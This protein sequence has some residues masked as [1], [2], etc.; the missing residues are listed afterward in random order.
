MLGRMT[1]ETE[2]APRKKRRKK[3][4]ARCGDF[5]KTAK[6][7]E[8]RLCAACLDRCDELHSQP[9]SIASLLTGGRQVLTR[10]GLGPFG[11]A[12]ALVALGL[13]M[14]VELILVGVDPFTALA[15]LTLYLGVAGAFSQLLLLHA[16]HAQ[17]RDEGAGY[18]TLLGRTLDGMPRYLLMALHVLF[19]VLPR[20][21]L[22]VV[23]GVVRSAELALA[24]PIL[25]LEGRTPT[26]A[27]EESIARTR[28]TWGTYLAAIWV[29]LTPVSLFQMMLRQGDEPYFTLG[30][31]AGAHAV[32]QLLPP[33]IA[34]ALHTK[35]RWQQ[36]RGKLE[37][38]SW[39]S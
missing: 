27:L 13:W 16:W 31:G 25:V 26:E 38:V 10:T 2:V 11:T 15:G 8:R 7:G 14:Q 1:E 30:V 4:C 6:L 33:A 34:L 18:L 24:P 37:P 21:L 32:T 20:L 9:I 28:S 36:A 23:P 3:P 19:S 35:L 12:I 39:P 5:A 29:V 22:F 17:L